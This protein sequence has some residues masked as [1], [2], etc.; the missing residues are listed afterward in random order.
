MATSKTQIEGLIDI[1]LVPP[2]KGIESELENAESSEWLLHVYNMARNAPYY[3]L[4]WDQALPPAPA[5]NL[6]TNLDQ[7]FLKQITPKQFSQNMNEAMGLNE[8]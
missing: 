1:G 3:D 8:G 6:L 5:Q 4:S 7:L 2:V